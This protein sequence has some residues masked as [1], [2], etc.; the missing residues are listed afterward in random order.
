[1]ILLTLFLFSMRQPEA[2]AQPDFHFRFMARVVS[3]DS[4]ETALRDCHIINKTQRMGTVSNEFGDFTITANRQDSIEFSML[5]YEKLIITAADSMFTNNRTVRLKPMSYLLGSVD[6]GLFSSY[7]QFKR[8]FN[9]METET[10]PLQINPV[11]RFEIA[12]RLLPGQGGVHVPLGVSPVTFLYNLLSREGKR[13]RYYR[14]LIDRT[15]DYIVI[16]EKFNGDVVRQLTGLENDELVRFMSYCFFTKEYLLHMPQ[17]EINREIMK[18]YRQY[19]AE[20]D[21]PQG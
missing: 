21:K 7:S 4:A 2:G 8:D 19:I 3:G 20:K 13:Q 6:I 12:P 14:S 18:K 9:D 1:M 16:G 17:D 5:G 11:S 10:L 15:A